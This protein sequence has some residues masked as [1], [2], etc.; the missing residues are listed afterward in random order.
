M[1][2]GI[3]TLEIILFVMIIS[4]LAG[5]AI[6][7]AAKILDRAALDY[8]TKKFYTDLRFVQ[9]FDR[10]A[11]MDDFH[12]FES[13]KDNRV[14][15]IVRP[16]KYFFSKV[17]AS[18]DFGEHYFSRGVTASQKN[19]SESW[20]IKFDDMGKVDPAVSGHLIL[21]SRFGKTYVVINSVGRFRGSHTP[22]DSEEDY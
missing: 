4:L 14:A 5:A 7:N 12:A 2:K 18:K 15:L 10:M 9:S 13:T 17:S 21:T 1:Q 20:Q 6:P 22:P 19:N 8:E 11:R 16:E 3:A